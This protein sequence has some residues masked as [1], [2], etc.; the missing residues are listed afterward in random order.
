LTVVENELH[1]AINLAEGQKTG[2]YLDQ[3]DNRAAVAKLCA[4]KRVLDAFS[5]TGGFGL[6]AAKAGAT[7]VECVDASAAAL[8]LAERNAALNGVSLG[9]V[10]ADVFHH[11]G[12]LAKKNKTYDV[13]ILDPPKFAR[14]RKALPEAIRGYRRLHQMALK[15]LAKDGILVSCC[16]TGLVTMND[17]EDVI[18]QTAQAAKR[19]LQVLERRGPSADHPTAVTCRESGYLKCII[20]RVL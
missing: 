3:R 15:L 6:Y 5:Y 11:L 7:S 13:V 14:N 12:E 19:D 8:Q 4:G 17:L 10:N 16:C 9:F 2:F 18:E 1:F 20:S